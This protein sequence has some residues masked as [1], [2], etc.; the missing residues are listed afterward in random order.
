MT[1]VQNA[2]YYYRSHGV[3]GARRRSVSCVCVSLVASAEGL[4][5]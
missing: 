5:E 1:D 2:G 4:H 3:I